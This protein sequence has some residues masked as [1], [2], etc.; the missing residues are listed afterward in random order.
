[1]F[2]L[3][4]QLS[5]HVFRVVF[6]ISMAMVLGSVG[7][8]ALRVGVDP[9]GLR[10]GAE[11]IVQTHLLWTLFFMFTTAALVADAVLRDELV[12]FAPILRA[13]PVRW[14]DLVLGRFVGAFAAI[15][16]CFTSVPIGIVAGSAM[17]WVAA[18]SV[19]PADPESFAFAFCVMAIPNLL[20]SASVGFVLA[21]LA[22]SL[23]AA[24]VGAIVL[25]ILYG[26][27]ARAG[28]VLLPLFEPFGFAA[29]DEATAGWGGALLDAAVPWDAPG[30]IANRLFVLAMSA[31]LLGAAAMRPHSAVSRPSSADRRMQAVDRV[32]A[33]GCEVS[34]AP[35][36][37]SFRRQFRARLVLEVGQIVRT[38]VFAALLLLGIANAAAAMWPVRTSADPRL[39]VVTLSKAFQPAPIVVAL[40]FTGE[41]RWSERERGLAALLA[42]T[43]LRSAA[44]LLPKFLA[45]AIVLVAMISAAAITALVLLAIGGG[46]AASSLLPA[47][48]GAACY[49]ALMF[50]IVAMFLQAIA[51]DK[52]AGWGFTVLFLVAT[53]TLDRLGYVDPLYR[54]GRYPGWPLAPGNGAA[55]PAWIYQCWWAAVGALLLTLAVAVARP[56]G[57]AYQPMRLARARPGLGRQ[58]RS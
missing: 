32:P 38:P 19:G 24:L 56:T 10:N 6:A 11:A 34:T 7:I 5:G 39:V 49:N 28:A 47:W 9:G 12:G 46:I 8:D 48:F 55:L 21:T 15:L 17:P 52:L 14:R 4:Q 3:R 54:Y 26:L 25:L 42:A 58:R 23:G 31:A 44:F 51:P 43:P 2:E 29:Y 57:P 50:A 20:L 45:I 37:P 22:R 33:G 27:G 16:L 35:L 13:A 41:L 30:L 40:F 53:L 36:V 1:M 18:G